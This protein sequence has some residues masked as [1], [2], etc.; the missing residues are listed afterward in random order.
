MKK[1][2]FNGIH[3]KGTL[4]PRRVWR[5]GEILEV[6]EETAEELLLETG[7]TLVEPEK[8]RKK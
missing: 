4:R 8:K 7:F 5:R 6:D 2:R 3:A 1:I